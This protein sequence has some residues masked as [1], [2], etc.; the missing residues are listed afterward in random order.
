MSLPQSLAACNF[1]AA[2]ASLRRLR[3]TCFAGGRRIC[4]SGALAC[5]LLL[6]GIGTV[7]A[8]G[9]D[10]AP[11]DAL[12][13]ANVKNGVVNYPGFQDNQAFRKYIDDLARPV[14][15]ESKADQLAY[16]IN[17]YNALAIEGI[18]E[19]LSPS[20][21]LGRARYFK[22]KDWTLNGRTITLY[23]L[24]HQIIRPLGEPR[25]HFAIICASKSCP[26]LRSEA[27]VPARLDAQLD[28]QARQFVNDD[29]RN[30]FDPA[31]RTA[32]LSEIFKWFDEDFKAAAGS[33]QKYIARYVADPQIARGLATDGYKIEWIDYDWNLNGIPPKG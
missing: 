24:E 16:Y 2:D 22:F 11:F 26:F 32:H 33:V 12:L 14:R 21:L 10:Q 9:I 17:A 30:R 19:G 3:R 27:Y 20:S 15:L 31:T 6:V 25:I 13:R 5:L 23:D 4:R 18:L 8:Q 7:A 1:P 29:F 28:E